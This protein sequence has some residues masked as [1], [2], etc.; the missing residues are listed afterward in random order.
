MEHLIA[1]QT[2]RS[3]LIEKGFRQAATFSWERAAEQTMAV[4][5]GCVNP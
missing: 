3:K 5:K 2:L 4:Y 1:D